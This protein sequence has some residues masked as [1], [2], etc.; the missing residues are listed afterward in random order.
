MRDPE[1]DCGIP[2]F[3]TAWLANRRGIGVILTDH[4][5]AGLRITPLSLGE[6]E[7]A[8][9]EIQQP[10][11]MRR[12]PRIQICQGGFVSRNGNAGVHYLPEGKIVLGCVPVIGA[13]L[14]KT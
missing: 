13:G 11:S 2:S 10:V 6:P 7:P 12:T 3:D 5:F 8:G 1:A 4:T 14:R 9:F